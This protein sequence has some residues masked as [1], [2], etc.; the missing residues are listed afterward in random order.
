MVLMPTVVLMLVVASGVGVMVFLPVLV[1]A[2]LETV[3]NEKKTTILDNL[4]RR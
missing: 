4:G 3:M 2:E 1:S